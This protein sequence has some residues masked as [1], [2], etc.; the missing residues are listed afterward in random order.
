MNIYRI[1]MNILYGLKY[2]K[3]FKDIWVLIT[4]SEKNVL[5]LCFGD[6]IIAK[7]CRK[8]KISWTGYD[9]NEYFVKRAEKRGFNAICADITKLGSLPQSDVC[10]ICG[11]LYH[12]KNEVESIFGMMLNSSPKIIVSEPV[13]NV[14]SHK[15]IT[16]KISGILTNA[17]KGHENFRFTETSILDTLNNLRGKYGFFY[18]IISTGHD[19]LI[20]INHDRN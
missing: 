6:V 13:I 11:S 3:R 5:E 20:E 16:G 7:E 12:F 8:R 15:G 4:D 17:G 9:I 18:K 19:I 2:K 14:T 10:I 1:T